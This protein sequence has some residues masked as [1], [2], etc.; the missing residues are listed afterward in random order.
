MSANLLNPNQQRHLGV[1]LRLL[2]EDFE[3]LAS[4]LPAGP[5]TIES[6][7]EIKLIR[8]RAES[9]LATI[10]LDLPTGADPW[11]RLSALCGAWLVHLHD[12]HATKLAAYGPV[13]PALSPHLDP[14]VVALEDAV[15]ALLYRFEGRR[16]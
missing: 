16:E 7:S 5:R 13:S 2:V 8:E 9:I 4:T 15:R 10:G 6:R 12:L 11:R 14:K 1:M 3:D